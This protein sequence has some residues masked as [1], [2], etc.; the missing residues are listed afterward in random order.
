[1]RRSWVSDDAPQIGS[2][3]LRIFQDDSEQHL[4]NVKSWRTLMYLACNLMSFDL[5]I[6]FVVLLLDM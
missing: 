5:T 3:V 1:M 4:C 6:Y 2:D